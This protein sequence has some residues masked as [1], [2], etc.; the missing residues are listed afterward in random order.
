MDVGKSGAQPA[1]CRTADCNAP[2]WAERMRP[3]H[4]GDMGDIVVIEYRDTRERIA[5]SAR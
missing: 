3:A 1:E 4:A 5:P 2:E